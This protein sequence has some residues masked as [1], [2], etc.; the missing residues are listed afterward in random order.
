VSS[1]P[2]GYRRE[3]IDRGIKVRSDDIFALASLRDLAWLVG[4]RAIPVLALLAFPLLGGLVST[5]FQTVVLNTLIISLLALSWDL[6]A[7]AGLVSLGQALFFGVGGYLS[8]TLDSRLGLPLVIGIPLATLI[9]AGLATL[10][11]YPLL[12]LR[13]IYFGLITFALP[14]MLERV[15]V[16]TGLLGGTEGL[17]GLTPFPSRTVEL[18]L[19]TVAVLVTVILFRRLATSDWGLVYQAIR[20]NDRAVVAAGFDI[21]RRKAQVVFLAALPAAFAGAFA[22]HRYQVVGLSAFSSD[23]S[24][25]PLTSAVIG[26][27]GSFMGAL[28]GSVILVPLSELMRAAGSLRVVVYSAMLLAFTIGLPEGLFRFLARKWGQTERL[29]PIE[30]PARGR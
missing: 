19:V 28:V 26:G 3:R 25:L 14:I 16:A 17:P 6:L 8:G 5:Y 24:I 29:V 4:P 30:E 11:L 20:D 21:Q 2:H 9:G 10:L 18:Y 23:N 27:P 7:S 1:P 22:A 15:V 12:R 13:G